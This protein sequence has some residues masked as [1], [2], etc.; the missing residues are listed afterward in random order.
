MR[1]VHGADDGAR[2]SADD[3]AHGSGDDSSRHSPGCSAAARAVEAG[4]EAK[5]QSGG[6]YHAQDRTHFNISLRHASL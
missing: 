1:A 2:P 3:G 5:H 6:G 4:R